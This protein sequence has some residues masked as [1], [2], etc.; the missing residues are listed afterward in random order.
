MLLVTVATK[1]ERP[2]LLVVKRSVCNMLYMHTGG[3]STPPPNH[4]QRELTLNDLNLTN[5]PGSSSKP[6]LEEV[7]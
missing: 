1:S 2:L 5:G 4:L 3:V 7:R 6:A